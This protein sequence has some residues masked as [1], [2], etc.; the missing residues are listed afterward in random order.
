MARKKQNTK[1]LNTSTSCGAGRHQLSRYPLKVSF[2]GRAEQ[3]TTSA[4]EEA[5]SVTASLDRITANKREHPRAPEG[6]RTLGESD[7]VGDFII[8]RGN[9]DQSSNNSQTK[10]KKKKDYVM[11]DCERMWLK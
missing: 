7:N 3:L 5:A 10:K 9:V 1:T 2:P 11:N 4:V 8:A 6:R